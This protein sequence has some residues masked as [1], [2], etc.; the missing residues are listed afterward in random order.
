VDETRECQYF[1]SSTAASVKI[2]GRIIL[3]QFFVVAIGDKADDKE[4]LLR[5]LSAAVVIV[6]R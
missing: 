1:A 6:F 2:G 3:L 5:R 4:F